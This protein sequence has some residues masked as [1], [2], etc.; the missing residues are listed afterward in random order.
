MDDFENDDADGIVFVFEEED[1]GSSDAV[2]T[3]AKAV[4]ISNIND[5]KDGEEVAVKSFDSILGS[6]SGKVRAKECKYR[7]ENQGGNH[8]ACYA[9]MKNGN[10]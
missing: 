10:D 1:E 9:V 2:S 4:K 8:T 3:R 5:I 7:V 6:V